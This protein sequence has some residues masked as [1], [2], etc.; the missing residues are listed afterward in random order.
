MNW[1]KLL[2]AS[3][4]LAALLIVG[5][6]NSNS[7]ETPDEIQHAAIT[8]IE[9]VQIDHGSTPLLLEVAEVETLQATLLLPR[10]KGGINMDE[11]RGTLRIHLQNN[12]ANMFNL[13]K[14]PQLHVI[15]PSHFTGKVVVKGSSGNVIGDN[16]RS[17]HLDIQG[18]SGNVT[19]RYAELN[20]DLTV[21]LHSGSV[22]MQLDESEPSATWLLQT[23]SGRRSIDFLLD[24]Q[25]QKKGV[26]AGTTGTGSVNVNLETKSGNITIM[27]K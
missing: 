9:T 10:G 3:I 17:H 1:I 12:I 20:H 26:T 25:Q 22:R 11:A 13:G 16:L 14:M 19:L 27:S 24:E 15:I 18:K 8:D 23:K 2:T 7:I 5:A 6:C 21:S 4:L